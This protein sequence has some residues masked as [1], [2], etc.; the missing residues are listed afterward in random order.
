MNRERR[1]TRAVGSLAEEVNAAVADDESGGDLR[2]RRAVRGADVRD[3]SFA[4]DERLPVDV[5]A[6]GD[7]VDRH[8][9]RDDVVIVTPEPL[10]RRSRRRDGDDRLDVRLAGDV[11]GE[12]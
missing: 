4:V 3:E 10:H 9:S 2:R 5:A 12:R 11:A 7:V 8:R 6:I 1:A